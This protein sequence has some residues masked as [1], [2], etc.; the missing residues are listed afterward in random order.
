VG[1][2]PE[3]FPSGLGIIL[4]EPRDTVSEWLVQLIFQLEK[5]KRFG[6]FETAGKVSERIILS[7]NLTRSA[8]LGDRFQTATLLRPIITVGVIQ[9]IAA[10]CSTFGG[11]HQASPSANNA[12]KPPAGS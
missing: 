5:K 12:I 8:S 10:Q 2:A 7:M 9:Q 1:A 3:R 6:E 4:C 11:Q